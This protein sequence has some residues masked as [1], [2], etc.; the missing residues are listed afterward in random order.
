MLEHGGNLRQAAQQYGIPLELWCDLSTGINPNHYPIPDIPMEAWHRLPEE[1]DGLIEAAC[2]YYDCQSLIATAGSQAAIQ[3]LPQLR[4]A[5]HIAMPKNM[6]QEHAHAWQSHG[7]QV[8]F[9]AAEPTLEVLEKVDVLILC[10]PNNPTGQRF[11][12]N[13]LLAWHQQLTSRGAWL[14]V[15]EAFMD[16]TPEDSV[17]STAHLPNLIVLRSL[18]KFFGLAGARVG[19]LLAEKNMLALAQEKIG[20]WS[21]T[22][23]SRHMASHALR[24]G[25]W[26]AEASKALS[27][28][29]QQLSK[30]LHQY[31]LTPT[32][33]TDFFQFVTTAKAVAIHEALAKQGIWVRLFKEASALRFGLPA[34]RHWHQLEQALKEIP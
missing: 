32:G 25:K 34:H 26:Q 22:G 3:V 8:T 10:N 28:N 11:N 24:N 19:F 29:S 23:P 2:A 4:S 21:I 13:Q 6:Y 33:G 5:C 12:K 16:T 17:A 20:P 1:N 30:L 14:I 31:G 7:H 15:D 27:S 9:F 18:G